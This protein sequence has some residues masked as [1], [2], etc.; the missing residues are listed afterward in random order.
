MVW[1]ELTLNEPITIIEKV[2]SSLALSEFIQYVLR[3]EGEEVA[4][5]IFER[6][7]EVTEKLER[8]FPDVGRVALRDIWQEAVKI[9]TDIMAEE[10]QL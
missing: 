5:F 6:E 7:A 8:K 2:M 3:G 9:W 4:S 1:Y 10:V